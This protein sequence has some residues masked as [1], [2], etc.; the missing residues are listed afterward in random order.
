MVEDLRG[1]GYPWIEEDSKGA[2]MSSRSARRWRKGGD[3]REG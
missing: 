3:G 2:F 1:T